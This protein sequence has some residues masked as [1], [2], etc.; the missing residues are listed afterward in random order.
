MQIVKWIIR[1]I[2]K[3]KNLILFSAW[4][5][6]KYLDSSMYMYEYLLSNNQFSV[7]W[8]T[9]NKEIYM[10]CIKENKPVV[11]A[12]TIKGVWKQIRAEMLVSSVQISDFN[13]WFMAKCIYF[14]LGHGFPIKSSGFEQPEVTKRY[15]SYFKF[16]TKDIKYYMDA[17][18]FVTM[19]ICRRAW[20]IDSDHIVFCNKARTDVFFDNDLREGKNVIIETFL[21]TSK[22]RKT[23]VYMP[24]HRSCGVVNMNMNQLLDLK[25]IQ[26]LCIKNNAIF[27]IKKH[28]Y[29]REEKED[30]SNYSNIFDITNEFIDP[31]VLLY[32]ADILI[33]DYSAAYIDYLLLDRPILFYA[34][35]LENF[36]TSERDLYFK[37]EDNNAGYKPKNACELVNCLS[38]ICSSWDDQKHYKGRKELRLRYFD[39]D[40]PVGNAR[41][42]VAKIIEHMLLGEYTPKWGGRN[43]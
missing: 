16:V 33:S 37:F 25:S 3:E 4:F 21:K 7:F 13:N 39:S 32:Q 38:E 26:D 43:T 29:H 15:I 34:Y 22:A 36:L 9:R 20:N 24:T 42:D 40:V 12:N 5:G 8:F 28:F 6:Q 19:N 23:I 10:H 17:S 14:D 30:F 35:D 41:E 31:Q 11:Y 1:L 18:S 2:P 27:L